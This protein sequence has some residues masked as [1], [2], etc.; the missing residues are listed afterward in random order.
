M[1]IRVVVFPGLPVMMAP[2]C[3]CHARIQLGAMPIDYGSDNID[4]ILVSAYLPSN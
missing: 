3:V 2:L 4:G 1:E